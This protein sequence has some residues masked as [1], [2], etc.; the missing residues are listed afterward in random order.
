[1]LLEHQLLESSEAN[2]HIVSTLVG[3]L[4][5]PSL[6]PL[7]GTDAYG[8]GGHCGMCLAFGRRHRLQCGDVRSIL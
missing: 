4:F 3:T 5:F 8:G 1:M 6:W 7:Q 2:H